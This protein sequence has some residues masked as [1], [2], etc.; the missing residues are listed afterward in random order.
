MAENGNFSRAGT[1]LVGINH[2]LRN[3]IVRNTLHFKIQ[4]F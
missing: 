2:T 3:D 4:L 1:V